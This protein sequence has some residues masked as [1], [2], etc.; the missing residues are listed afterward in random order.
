MRNLRFPTVAEGLA[1][2][3]RI[4]KAGARTTGLWSEAQIYEHLAHSFEFSISKYPSLVPAFIRKTLGRL[5]FARMRSKGFMASGS[6]NPAAPKVRE[7]GDA[8]AVLKRLRNAIKQFEAYSGPMAEH[9]FFGKLTKD[10][11]A[12][13]HAMHMANHLAFLEPEQSNGAKASAAKGSKRK[14]LS[15]VRKGARAKARPVKPAKKKF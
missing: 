9:P 10:E 8:N 5:I 1:E 2:L 4:E 6:P 15:P 13:L 14:A 3:D 11:F 7:E 12:H